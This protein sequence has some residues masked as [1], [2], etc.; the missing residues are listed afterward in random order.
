MRT[1]MQLQGIVLIL[2]GMLLVL[3]AVVND[4][5]LPMMGRG[6]MGGI[7]SFVLVWLGLIVGILGVALSLSKDRSDK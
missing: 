5:W 7:F 4:N 1:Q 2:F 6:I 3:V